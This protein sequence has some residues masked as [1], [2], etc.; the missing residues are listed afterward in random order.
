[1][2]V[3]EGA[4]CIECGGEVRIPDDVMKNEIL[5][6]PECGA[7]L[8]VIGVEPLELDLAPQVEEDWG[9]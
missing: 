3:S 9:E 1:M 2:N 5:L 8:E 4:P 6:C 7:E